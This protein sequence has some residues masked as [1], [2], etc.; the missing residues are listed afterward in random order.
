MTEEEIIIRAVELGRQAARRATQDYLDAHG[1]RDC[2]G[3]AWLTVY[4]DGRSR[5]GRALIKAGFKKT[6]GQPGIQV[7]NPSGHRTQALTAK[8]V[9]AEAMARV[10][11]E[12][13]GVEAYAGSRM[14]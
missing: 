12:Q 10:L 6:Y 5:V 14:D 7:W 2:C 8:E 1:D 13:L 11:R 3:F 9:G 4:T